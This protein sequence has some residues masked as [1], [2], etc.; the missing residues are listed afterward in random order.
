MWER[1]LPRLR[2]VPN[3]V[4]YG[5]ESRMNLATLLED[6]CLHLRDAESRRGQ[7][8]VLSGGACDDLVIAGQRRA[9]KNMIDCE[10]GF[11]RAL[12]D[13]KDITSDC[14]RVF[15]SGREAEGALTPAEECYY[16][17]LFARLERI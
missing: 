17:A 1:L 4:A 2:E 13:R 9:A 6:N 10:G 14:E 15:F 3:S 12:V 16:F 11:D 8:H 7:R 5:D